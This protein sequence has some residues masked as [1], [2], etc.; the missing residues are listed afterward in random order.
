MSDVPPGRPLEEGFFARPVGEVA[1]DLVGCAFSVD[2]VGGTIVEVERYQEDDP[3]SHSFR[4]PTER[5]R[6][7]FGRPGGLYVYRS[8]G[9]HWCV[10][11]VAE[12]EG[13]GAAVLLRAI[14]PLWGLE[15]MRA[16]RGRENER[17]LCS[18]PG[19]LT[20]ALGIDGSLSGTS[21]LSGGPVLVAHPTGPRPAVVAG[22]RVGISKAVDKPWRYG[23]EGSRFVSRPRMLGRAA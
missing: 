6:P 13:R 17:D 20:E 2:G 7:M 18:G 4:G 1:R 19:K 21:A 9:V 15:R 16:R 23:A 5:T 11:L 10:N 3:A 12:G 14:E 22:P 8:Y